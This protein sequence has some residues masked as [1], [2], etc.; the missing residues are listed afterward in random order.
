MTSLEE[1]L[2]GKGHQAAS[3]DGPTLFSKPF[4]THFLTRLATAMAAGGHPPRYVCETGFGAGHSALLWIALSVGPAAV[5][6]VSVA[7]HSFD[8]GLS[9]H[10]VPAHDYIDERWPD[11]LFLYLGDSYVTVPQMGDYYPEVACDVVY[12]DGAMTN[13]T[14]TADLSHFRARAAPGAVV[15]LAN[16]RAGSEPLRAW[17]ALVASQ[18]LAWEG[19]VLEA[20]LAP[21]TSDALVYGRY[22]AG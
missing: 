20:P 1:A 22:R 10:I 16:A 3:F 11:N 13:E 8:H 9:K 17:E 14:V 19:T 12:V 18:L 2:A 5:L 21:D 7:V 4:R 15:V 6:P